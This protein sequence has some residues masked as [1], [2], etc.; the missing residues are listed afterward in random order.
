M[1]VVLAYSG[2]LD[3]SI[4]VSVL[5]EKYDAEVITVLVDLGQP[6]EEIQDAEERLK[7]L[8]VLKHHNID[9]RREFVNDYIFPAIKGNLQH[10]DCYITPT[11]ARPL[12]ALKIVE[13]AQKEGAPAVA[14]GATERGNDQF[15][16]E[17][18]FQMMAPELKI[19]TPI[20]DQGFTRGEEAEYAREH[21]IPLPEGYERTRYAV[22]VNIYGRAVCGGPLEDL[23]IEPEEEIYD[24]TKSPE[25]ATDE[26]EEMSI[27]FEK[28]C[29]VSLNGEKMD[30]VK[31]ISAVG[32]IA[33]AHGVG[34]G[35]VIH[36]RLLGIKTR[37]IIEAPA[38]VVLIQAHRELEKLV[39]TGDELEFKD[40]VDKKLSSLAHDG[41]WFYPL[42]EDLFAFVEKSQEAVTGEVTLK[43]YKGNA[44]VVKKE[45]PYAIYDREV[46]SYEAKGLSP[47]DVAGMTRLHGMRARL[48]RKKEKR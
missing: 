46:A 38:A 48:Y 36:Q 5:K 34:R 28:G 33:G 24:L 11:L 12:I 32:K 31:L 19:L 21:G 2:G 15:I 4:A 35:D 39:L 26:S 1:K 10:E 20:R 3:T 6:R 42:T 27:G 47:E 9:A 30:G 25:D 43:L 45:S 22:D 40:E 44:R 23:N 7:E 16:Y 17:Y 8:G 14:H 18:V 37:S 29:P 41:L 13:I